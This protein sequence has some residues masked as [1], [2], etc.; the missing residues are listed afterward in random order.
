MSGQFDG[1]GDA[2][3]DHVIDMARNH[4]F[5]HDSPAGV[6]PFDRMRRYG[7]Q[8]SYA[9]ENIA[10]GRV[11]AMTVNPYE[12][13]WLSRTDTLAGLAPV[14]LPQVTTGLLKP[15]AE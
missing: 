9:G 13:R 1:L 14:P 8:F 5:D 7:C 6:T 15:S 3:R 12:A 10:L 4:Y 2:A 11:E